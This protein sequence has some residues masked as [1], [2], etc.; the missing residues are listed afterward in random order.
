MCRQI[1]KM[2]VPEAELQMRFSGKMKGSPHVMR[3]ISDAKNKAAQKFNLVPEQLVVHE[4]FATN[5]G[6]KRFK[7]LRY[8]GRGRVGMEAKRL[9]HVNLKVVEIDFD[10][11]VEGQKQSYKKNRW[12]ERKTRALALWQKNIDQVK[13][14]DELREKVAAS[15]ILPELA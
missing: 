14:I 8:M 3:L 6:Q 10:K 2:T 15:T 11:L 9:C 5:V 4:C 1:R 7:K 12:I 13:E